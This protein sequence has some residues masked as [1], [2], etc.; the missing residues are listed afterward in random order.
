MAEILVKP[1][2]RLSCDNLCVLEKVPAIAEAETVL[3]PRE[4]HQRKAE[5]DENKPEGNGKHGNHPP[6][7]H[8]LARLGRCAF[9][10]LFIWLGFVFITHA[11]GNTWPRP[12]V[13]VDQAGVKPMGPRK[14]DDPD[15]APDTTP[16]LP[17]EEPPDSPQELP[18]E[19]GVPDP[20]P[21]P[22]TP[23]V[24]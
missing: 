9:N 5:H 14:P 19:H 21:Q 23:E 17:P 8:A 7:H 16:D 11:K 22:Q 18:P 24:M 1:Q 20:V 12:R 10:G 6:A 13:P 15:Q 4:H 2:S 3:T